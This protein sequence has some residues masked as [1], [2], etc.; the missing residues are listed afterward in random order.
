MRF[1]AGLTVSTSLI[2]S[3][4]MFSSPPS[5]ACTTFASIGA[6]ND[7]GGMKIAKNRDSLS[8]YQQ[9]EVKNEQGENAYLGL[10]YNYMDKKPYPFIAAGINEYGLTVVNNEAS[11]IY[12]SS[13]FNDADQSAVIYKLLKD[14]RSVNDVLKDK[15]KLFGDGKANFL[16][17]ADEMDAVMVEVGPTKGSFALKKA[18]DNDNR[19]YHTNHYVLRS[20]GQFNKSFYADSQDRYTEIKELMH[21]GRGKLTM[22]G[23]YYHAINGSHNGP[24]NS[25]FRFI[26]VAS[27]V[28]DYP[29]NG[30]PVL[31]V[32]LRAPGK[33]YERY[34]VSL[35]PS[36]WSCPPTDLHPEPLSP[37]GI[38]SEPLGSEKRYTYISDGL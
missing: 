24:A 29:E 9:L 25:I 17:I 5:D 37:E 2:L 14:Y 21:E 35:T 12:H 13:K 18:I 36:F 7:E 15:E 22:Q 28:V 16:I 20:M 4:L 23:N 30:I 34:E 33:P 27:W 1:F 38:D 8:A 19:L 10:F 32:W 11:S 3:S 26:T 6:A 31:S